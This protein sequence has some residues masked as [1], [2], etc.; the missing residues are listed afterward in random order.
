MSR[1]GPDG[2]PWHTRRASRVLVVSAGPQESEVLLV[3]DSDPGVPGVRWWVTPGGGID[4]GESPAEAA[5]RE[6]HEET[7]HRAD[8]TDLHGP[9]AHRVVRH[10]YSDRVLEQEEWF[11][12]LPAP[13]FRVRTDGHTASER[14]KLGEIRWWRLGD[15]AGTREWIWPADLLDLVACADSPQRWP[16]ELGLVT[17]ESTVPWGPPDPARAK[18]GNHWGP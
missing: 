17:E 10:G 1:P 6:V 8:P 16:L 13:R 2:R 4:P 15:L 18:G 14:R 5:L 3:Q 7:G 12:L 11:F 9:V